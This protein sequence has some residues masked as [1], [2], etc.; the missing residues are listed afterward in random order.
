MHRFFQYFSTFC[1]ALVCRLLQ[2]QRMSLPL[3]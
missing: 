1:N 2:K 3:V